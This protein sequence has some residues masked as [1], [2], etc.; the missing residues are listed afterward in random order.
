MSI[1]D[2]SPWV[3][4]P[5]V[6]LV[7]VPAGGVLAWALVRLAD[8]IPGRLSSRISSRVPSRAADQGTGGAPKRFR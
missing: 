7:A 5:L 4:V 3:Q 1:F 2:F 6:L 8:L